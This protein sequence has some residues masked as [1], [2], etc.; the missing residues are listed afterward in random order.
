MKK[1]I[2]LM[3]F[4]SVWCTFVFAHQPRLVFD[5]PIGE[6]IQVNNPEI[7]QAF[8]G[9]LAGQEDV[10]EIKSDVPFLLYVNI[11]APDIAGSRTDF[12]VEI[13]EN[14]YEKYTR[15]EWWSI[16]WESF[17]EPF[18]WDTYLKWPEIE[19]QVIEGTYT[20]KVS[21]PDNQWKYSL[22]VGKI[23]SFP[24]NEMIATY[25]NMPA[26]KM[27]FFEKPR[28]SVFWNL[29]SLW[30]FIWIIVFVVL[31]RWGIKIVHHIRHK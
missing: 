2:M 23:E 29:V 17:Y 1:L 26:L 15:L 27:Q 7:S 30:M 18:G 22:A 9:N 6:V 12:T 24:F 28:Y 4:L 20:I 19:R 11:L 31:V 13:V 16:T 21:N 14:N 25:K 3:L 10:Y 8:Y 5:N